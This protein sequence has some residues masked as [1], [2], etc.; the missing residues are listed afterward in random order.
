MFLFFSSN[1]AETTEIHEDSSFTLPSFGFTLPQKIL[2]YDSKF[3]GRWYLGQ[4]P[5]ANPLNY[6]FK[7]FYGHVSDRSSKYDNLRYP[8]PG[9]Y[10]DSRIFA[11]FFGRSDDPVIGKI[12]DRISDLTKVY[13]Q[14]AKALIYKALSRNNSFYVHCSLD[15][16]S[17]PSYRSEEFVNSS[18]ATRATDFGDALRETDD[19]V[20]K[21]VNLL[22]SSAVLNN[23]V[24]ALFAGSTAQASIFNGGLNSP[25]TGETGDSTEGGVRVP[26][27]IRI[28]TK[29]SHYRSQQ[30]MTLADLH[31][32][33]L[34]LVSTYSG[35]CTDASPCIKDGKDF[36]RNLVK[37]S[38]DERIVPIY[39]GRTLMAVRAGRY[40]AHQYSISKYVPGQ[41]LDSL[42]S[43]KLRNI[44]NFPIVYDIVTDP[45]ERFFIGDGYGSSSPRYNNYSRRIK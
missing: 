40:K 31:H 29:V 4:R 24:I 45:S 38:S 20:G 19:F 3:I 44:T 37:G 28:P 9:L 30:V 26:G 32:T 15:A 21:L 16:L 8:N 25:F 13:F 41:F 2:S 5:E 17:H 12:E 1:N 36:S 14:E 27:I 18:N 35:G 39:L 23:T 42:T 6:G 7:H 22:S 43:Y 11:R 33:L 10:R 34:A